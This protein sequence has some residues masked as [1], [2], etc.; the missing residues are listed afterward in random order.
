VTAEII[1]ATI[2]GWKLSPLWQAFHP[3]RAFAPLNP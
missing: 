2:F 3:E 1:C